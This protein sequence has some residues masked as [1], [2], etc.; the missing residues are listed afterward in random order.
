MCLPP[1]RQQGEHAFLPATYLVFIT[2]SERQR[3]TAGSTERC[4]KSVLMDVNAFSFARL[5]KGKVKDRF[6]RKMSD[7]C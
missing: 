2:T 6:S 7:L 4:S 5:L 1:A 3:S